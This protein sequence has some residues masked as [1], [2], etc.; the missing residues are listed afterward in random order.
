MTDRSDSSHD[1]S[2]SSHDRTD[3]QPTPERASDSQSRTARLRTTHADA[4]TVAAALRPDNTDSMEVAVEG[5][6][7]VTTVSRKTTGGLQSTV[8]DTVVNLT[9]ADAIVDTTRTHNS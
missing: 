6:Q 1:R 7:L 8:D 9:V 3:A 4:E 5:D 2:D